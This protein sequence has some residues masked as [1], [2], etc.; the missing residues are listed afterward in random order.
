MQQ[1][2]SKKAVTKRNVSLIGTKGFIIC[3]IKL[4]VPS[5]NNETICVSFEEDTFWF[6]SKTEPIK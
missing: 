2:V 5:Y 1:K 4:K 6:S 3:V